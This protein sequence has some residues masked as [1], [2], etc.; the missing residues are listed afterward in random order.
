MTTN[1]VAK[2]PSF[3][4]A[5]PTIQHEP[6]GAY[7]AL[8]EEYSVYVDPQTGNY[9]LTRYVDVRQALLDV[10]TFKNSTGIM[11]NRWCPEA[12]DILAERGWRGMDTL[13]SNDP[14]GHGF[15]RALVDK[16]FTPPKVKEIEPRINQL[17]EELIDN[18]IDQQE[19]DFLAAYA[20][21]LPMYVIAEQLGIDPGLKDTFK[22]WSDT[23]VESTSP[24]TTT[25][26][27][28]EMAHI[29]VDMQQ[30]F[31][32]QIERVRAKPDE[33]L[34]SRLVHTEA[35]GRKLNMQEIQSLLLQILSAGNDTTTT[36]L[37]SGM[38]HLI[39]R[40]ELAEQ[41]GNDSVL[42]S[43]FVEETLRI[44]APLQCLW[45]RVANDIEISGTKIPEGALVELRFG[46]ANRDPRQF[47]CPAHVDLSRANARSHLTFG[48]G[49][50]FCI[51]NQLARAELRLSF[52]SLTRRLSNFRTTRGSDSYRWLE[53]YPLY[54]LRELWMTFDRR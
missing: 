26:R 44:M 35:E 30:Y 53:G 43:N 38:K 9:V 14:P 2:K 34:L 33:T 20:V 25:E 52:Q 36:T 40:P 47:G 21:P 16:V 51:G 3:S 24:I 28:V 49:I 22:L 13:V 17:L 19:I 23:A 37:A 11:G 8:R 12:D 50:H 48:A 46:S 15:Y 5:E 32:Q 1:E 45:R 39:E 42:V 6:F 41:M 29:L 31:A 4:F 27:Q 18:F 10:E 54:G 7:D